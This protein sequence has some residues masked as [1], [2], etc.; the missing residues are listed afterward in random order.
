VPGS[1]FRAPLARF[2]RAVEGPGGRPLAWTL[3]DYPGAWLRSD[4]VAGLT[5]AALIIPLSIGYASVA[6]LPPE[7][8]LYASMAPLIAYGDAAPTS[9]PEAATV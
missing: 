8:G 3:R 4:L 7:V 5:V 6:G 9:L 1:W 2:A